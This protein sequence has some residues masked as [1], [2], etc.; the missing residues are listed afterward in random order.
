VN[1]RTTSLLPIGMLVVLAALTFWLSRL[2]EDD[3]PRAP[4]RHDPDYIVERFQLRRFDQEGRL[5]HTLDGTRLTHFPDDDSTLAESPRL[6][7]HQRGATEISAKR[8][9]IGRDGKEVELVG[10]VNILRHAVAGDTPP[11]KLVTASLTVFPDEER[12]IGREAVTITQGRSVIR[13]TG[14]EV[15]NRTGVSVLHGRVQGTL[16]RRRTEKP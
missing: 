16:H 4:E 12:G 5:Q 6:I 13:G 3:K 8:A 7:Y 10:D 14:L 1:D 15:D 2:I 11:T 9:L